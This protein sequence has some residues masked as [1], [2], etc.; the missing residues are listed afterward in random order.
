M[1]FVHL[2]DL[3]LGK[4]L[5]KQSLLP[6]QEYILDQIIALLKENPPD[7][8]LIAGDVYDRS[9]PA[10]D[11]IELFNHFLEELS[12]FQIPIFIISGNHDSGE[13]LS[14]AHRSLKRADIHISPNYH[15]KITPIT[16]KKE[17]EEVDVCLLPFLKPA[18][19]QN[20]FPDQ[21]IQTYNDTVKTVVNEMDVDPS[22]PSVLVAHQFVTGAVTCDSEEISVGGSENVDKSIFKNFQYVALGHLHGP[23][24]VENIH[25]RYCGS[26][27]K[28]SFSEVDHAKSLTYV[29]VGKNFSLE[30]KPLTPLRDLVKIRGSYNQLTSKDFYER[31]G[32]DPTAYFHITLT[33]EN[34]LPEAMGRLRIIYPYALKLSYDNLR[35][36]H[37]SDI[38]KVNSTLDPLSVFAS[39]F[40][41]QHG[42]PLST[43]QAE[44]LDQ[45]WKE[46]DT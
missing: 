14:F 35:T 22:R 13:R 36:R 31:D 46:L 9:V 30:K 5:E 21:N 44:F 26:P 27:L 38:N 15:G 6:D 10:V 29:Q 11:A 25:I 45:I 24:N 17:G 20:Y 40:A 1:T 43:E 7:G 23:Q 39:L 41:E 37:D 28:Y 3:H 12:A 34:P 32:F 42:S 18:M 16:V 4:R 33:D 19:V 8:I 2:S